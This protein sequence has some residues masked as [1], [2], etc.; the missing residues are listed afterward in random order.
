LTIYPGA[1]TVY[2]VVGDHVIIA[3]PYNVFDEELNELLRMLKDTYD[4]AENEV[5]KLLA[6]TNGA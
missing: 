3:P 6:T 5:A 1:G 4:T 2:G